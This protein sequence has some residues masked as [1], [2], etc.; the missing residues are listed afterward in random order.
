MPRIAQIA[1]P[2]VAEVMNVVGFLDDSEYVGVPFQGLHVG[3]PVQFAE[4]PRERGKRA[5]IE[6]LVTKDEHQML[7][8]TG[9]DSGDGVVVELAGQVDTG[10]FSAE[11][12]GHSAESEPV[13]VV[14]HDDET[15]SG[16]HYMPCRSEATPR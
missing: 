10:H 16:V 2:A 14:A 3:M 6:R 9:S 1:V 15:S 12:A 5:W 8:Q 4:P 7:Q 11:R 13:G